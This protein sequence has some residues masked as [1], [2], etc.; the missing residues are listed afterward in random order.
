M[1]INVRHLFII[2]EPSGQIRRKAVCRSVFLTTWQCILTGKERKI[3]L[4]HPTLYGTYRSR[5]SYILL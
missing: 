3:Y 2:K 1:F 4:S 5:D